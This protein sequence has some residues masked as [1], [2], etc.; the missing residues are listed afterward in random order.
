M[1]FYCMILN[2]QPWIIWKK[3]IDFCSES[4]NGNLYRLGIKGQYLHLGF[5]K[6]EDY[7]WFM[8]SYGNHCIENYRK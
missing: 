3:I 5:V 8:L 7:N 2:T 6:E 4:F 1:K